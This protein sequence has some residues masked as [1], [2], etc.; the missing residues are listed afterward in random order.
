MA[1]TIENGV[2]I[3]GLPNKATLSN[4][5]LNSYS[6]PIAP[7]SGS[8]VDVTCETLLGQNLK[9]MRAHTTGSLVSTLGAGIVLGEGLQLSGTTLSGKLASTSVKGVASFSS[10]N[11]SVNSGNVAINSVPANLISGTTQG[12]ISG[13]YIGSGINA[14]NITTGTLSASRI[15]TGA[16]TS[17]RLGNAAVIA[18]KIAAGGVSATNQIADSIVTA[19]KLAPGAVPDTLYIQMSAVGQAIEAGK[20][21][22][23]IVPSHMV[24]RVVKKCGTVCQG[25]SATTITFSNNGS[26]IVTA[27]AVSTTASESTVSSGGT[28]T[29]LG[30]LTAKVV[31]TGTCTGVDVWFVIE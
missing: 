8:A 17:D 3:F 14:A 23:F 9:A 24:G 4:A 20:T 25:G 30:K 13:S 2:T 18:G 27:K 15:G 1:I 6:I 5:E 19:A 16:I 26:A 11:F 7:S 12:A 28:L 21:V 29:S 22:N 31:T 10:S